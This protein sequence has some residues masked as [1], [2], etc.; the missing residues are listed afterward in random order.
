MKGK[1]TAE[2]FKFDPKKIPT[3]PGCYLFLDEKSVILYIGKAKN[4]RARVKSYFSASKKSPKTELLVSKITE[5]QTQITASET[6]SLVLENNL[7]KTHLPK[8]NILLRDDKN[9]LYLRITNEVFPKFEITRRLIRDGSFYFGPKTSAKSLRQTIRFCQKIFGIRS[10]R[11]VFGDSESPVQILKNPENR[12]LPCLDFHVKKCSGPC[13]SEISAAKY[14]ENVENMKSFLRGRTGSVLKNLREKMKNFATQKNFEA[15]A[16]MRDLVFSIEN[17]TEKQAVQFVQNFDADFVHF[18]PKN[19]SFYFVRLLFRGG[20]MIDQNEVECGAGAFATSDSSE[21]LETFLSQFYPKVD[22]V[23]PQIFVPFALE[24][25]EN[26][27]AFLNTKII[28]SQKG[29]RRKILDLAQKSARYFA[30]KSET[31]KMS[32]AENF[33][34]SLPELCEVLELESARRIEC[35]DISHFSGTSTVASQAVFC[36]GRPAKSEYRKYKIRTLARGQIDDFAALSEVLTRRFTALKKEIESAAAQKKELEKV[37]KNLEKKLKSAK[38]V[39]NIRA[40]I[41]EHLSQIAKIPPPKIPDLIVIDGGK[42]QLSAVL[43]VAKS[44]DFAAFLPAGS[45]FD[46]SKNLISLA[47]KFETIFRPA[48]PPREINL[49]FES[50]ALQLLQR[51]RDEAHRFAITFNRADRRKNDQKSILDDVA[52]IGPATKK[53]IL[54]TFG[55]V[56]AAKKA[57]D[58]ELRKILNAAQLDRFRRI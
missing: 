47:K 36:D 15:A 43:E 52:G 38:N 37:V 42:G 8:F 5:I 24:N 18:Y 14:R 54:Q 34:K 50:P 56:A 1:K 4:L 29:N 19:K 44:F 46:S 40:E 55:S 49:P 33:G 27:N 11:L 53:K 30:E 2:K 39:E 32:A 28:Q 22:S 51:I 17:A 7:I 26:L 45:S 20:K 3:D 16:K 12:R 48:S 6:E 21:V 9:F 31:E 41:S 35:F 57:S 25:A 23:P 58:A 10:C 13:T